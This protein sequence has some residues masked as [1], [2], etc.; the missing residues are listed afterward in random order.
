MKR[1]VQATKGSLSFLP[2]GVLA[3]LLCLGSGPSAY[4]FGEIYSITSYYPNSQWDA[5]QLEGQEEID[6]YFNH[7]SWGV[8]DDWR[9]TIW[10]TCSG[11]SVVTRRCEHWNGSSWDTIQCDVQ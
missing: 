4:S 1:L 9:R 2:L 7:T 10:Y 8:T 3:I 6:C 11:S 5:A